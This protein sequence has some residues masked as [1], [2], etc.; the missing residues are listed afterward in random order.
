MEIG[1]LSIKNVLKAN[2]LEFR[3]SSKI[4]KKWFKTKKNLPLIHRNL[5]NF[6]CS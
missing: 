1:L 3:N 5:V 6:F 2:V 4:C